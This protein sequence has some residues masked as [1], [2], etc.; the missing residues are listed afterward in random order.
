MST[1]S[2]LDNKTGFFFLSVNTFY[3]Y[4]LCLV[5]LFGSLRW[6]GGAGFLY[7]FKEGGGGGG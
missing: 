6:D 1:E 5:K 3:F 7:R 4:F 2:Q